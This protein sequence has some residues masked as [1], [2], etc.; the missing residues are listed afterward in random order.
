MFLVVW[1]DLL[2]ID[3]LTLFFSQ[4]RRLFSCF[5]EQNASVA[6]ALKQIT[7]TPNVLSTESKGVIYN[8]NLDAPWA[9]S[10][11]SETLSSDAPQDLCPSSSDPSAAGRRCSRPAIKLTGTSL[12]S[13]CGC[14]TQH[15]GR[16]VM[17]R[18]R[19]RLN[20]RGGICSHYAHSSSLELTVGWCWRREPAL[21]LQHPVSVWR[22]W[23]V[24]E[25]DAIRWWII[26]EAFSSNKVKQ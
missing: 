8:I 5:S 20:S 22:R 2:N 14:L 3:N 19:E 17:A 12:L 26:K 6:S 9:D 10:N 24:A 11:G 15:S 16:S 4:Y 23:S 18:W 1:L 21:R 13:A 25:E 7:L